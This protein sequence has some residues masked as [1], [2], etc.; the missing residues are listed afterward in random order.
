M[1]GKWIVERKKNRR[2]NEGLMERCKMG[3]NG[4]LENEEKGDEKKEDEK[5]DGGKMGS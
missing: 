3:A 5:V 4:E 2:M 1:N